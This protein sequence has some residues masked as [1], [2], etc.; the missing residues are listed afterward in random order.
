MTRTFK[1]LIK[2]RIN[3][4]SFFHSTIVFAKSFLQSTTDNQNKRGG[5]FVVTDNDDDDDSC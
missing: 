4:F 1:M 2:K 5:S 3:R